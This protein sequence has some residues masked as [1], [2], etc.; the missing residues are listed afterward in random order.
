MDT[1]LENLVGNLIIDLS[2]LLHEDRD[3]V[4]AELIRLRGHWFKRPEVQAALKE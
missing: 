2:P 3:L 1:Q 4:L